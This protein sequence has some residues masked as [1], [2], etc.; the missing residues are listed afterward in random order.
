MNYVGV[1]LG[2]SV[3]WNEATNAFD[4]DADYSFDHSK[5]R[6]QNG[7]YNTTENKAFL[8]NVVNVLLTRG[9]HGLYIYAVNDD[10]RRKLMTLNQTTID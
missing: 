6:K 8:K 7:T 4:I 1:I 2:P 9:V 3:I 10:L 5:I